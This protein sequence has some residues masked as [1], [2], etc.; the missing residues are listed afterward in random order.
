MTSIAELSEQ[1]WSGACKTSDVGS[2]PF[3]FTDALE[4]VA[5]GVALYKTF[6]NV[7]VVRTE[8]GAVLI[9][10]GAFNPA[11]RV[12]SHAMIRSYTPDPIHT[13]IYTHG[14]ADH[15]YG[16]PPFLAE[17]R[18]KGWALP[19]IVGHRA[20]RT[21]M[22][23]YTETAGYNSIINAR[24]FGV[25]LPWPTE[26][27]FP[28]TE[29]DSHLDVSAG[30]LHLQLHHAR[31][32]T[33]DHTWVYAPQ[34]KLLFT[35]DLFIWA[36]PNAGNPQKVQR[37]ALEWAQALTKMATLGA[38]VMVPGHGVPIFGADR[39]RQALTETAEYL[40]SVY[41]QTLAHLNVGATIYDVIHGFEIPKH[42]VDRP[43]LLPV[44]DE[45]E[46]IARNIYR[47]LAGW[48]T[49]V[50]SELKPSRPEQLATEVASLAGG[51]DVLLRR[52]EEV[53]AAGDQRLACH[54]VEWAVQA[55]PDSK[56]AHTV[57]AKLYNARRESE[58]SLMAKGIFGAAARESS[59][60]T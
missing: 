24:Q 3:D 23:R 28:T 41:D 31:G 47:C 54:L 9:D 36:A 5:D 58:T 4:E 30:D 46:F 2:H 55:A 13:A 21:R 20:V 27:V 25:A 12:R 32:E 14:H 6:V 52:A 22:E 15:A 37:Y 18:D 1:L 16:L 59:E 11:M 56:E 34:S 60:K 19:N 48:Y 45:P 50:P 42:L 53:F 57:R 44:Y 40:Q 51:V 38:E 33:D 17:A 7:V 8:A 26:H 49:G 39:V 29:Y 35:G 43:Y 10:T